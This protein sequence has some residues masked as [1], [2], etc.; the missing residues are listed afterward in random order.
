MWRGYH[1]ELELLM[2]YMLEQLYI[3]GRPQQLG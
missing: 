2:L 3:A 1:L